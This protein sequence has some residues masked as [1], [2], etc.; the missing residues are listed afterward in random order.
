VRIDVRRR[1]REGVL[2][3]LGGSLLPDLLQLPQTR[4]QDGIIGTS[5]LRSQKLELAGTRICAPSHHF[6]KGRNK[7][8]REGGVRCGGP[9][10]RGLPLPCRLNNRWIDLF[11]S[12]GSRRPEPLADRPIKGEVPPLRLEPLPWSR[13]PGA[14][15]PPLVRLRDRAEVEDGYGYGG[16]AL[17]LV[18][19]GYQLGRPQA[20]F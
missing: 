16:G 19:L 14:R 7:E 4:A 1:D 11:G 20:C 18:E 6:K 15:V 12:S 2:H 3:P 8:K 5:G 9:A 13:R 10:R 17:L